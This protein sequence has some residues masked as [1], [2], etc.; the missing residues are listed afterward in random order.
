VQIRT[1]LRGGFAVKTPGIVP[2]VLIVGLPR[3]EMTDE[4]MMI[5]TPAFTQSNEIMWVKLQMRVKMKGFDMMD[6]QSPALT[7]TGHTSGFTQQ[8]LS[9]HSRPLGTSLM[10]I[11]SGHMCPMVSPP[12]YPLHGMV[13]LP[14]PTLTIPTSESQ[15]SQPRNEHNKYHQQRNQQQGVHIFPFLLQAKKISKSG[16]SCLSSILTKADGTLT[17]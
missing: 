15:E 9:S 10:T 5:S 1:D 2:N 6:L 14:H 12:R 4:Q 8:M 13:R 3:A 7:S 16:S 17:A 11:L